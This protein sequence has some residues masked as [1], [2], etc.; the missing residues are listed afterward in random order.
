MKATTATV[1]VNLKESD[2]FLRLVRFVAEVERLN[3]DRVDQEF[4]E[5][6]HALYTDLMNMAKA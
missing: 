4:E 6:I 2:H 1:N 5:A 3:A